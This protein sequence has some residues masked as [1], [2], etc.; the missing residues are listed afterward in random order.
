[1][2]KKSTTSRIPLDPCHAARGQKLVQEPREILR[3]LP[4]IEYR[5]MAEADWCCGGAGSYAL[6]HYDLSSKVP[7]R[8]ADNV[9]KTG[10]D[11]VATSCPACM[12]HLSYGLRRRGLS[13]RVLHI[14]E[15]IQRQRAV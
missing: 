1:L 13:T 2:F 15:L 6:F 10:A 14:F 3:S 5:E 11:V 12:I 9:V 8:K 7:D 4:G